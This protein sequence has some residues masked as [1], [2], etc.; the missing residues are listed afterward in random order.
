M[1]NTTKRV[2]PTNT[3]S[4]AERRAAFWAGVE[5]CKQAEGRPPSSPNPHMCEELRLCWNSG[6]NSVVE[7]F[8]W[9]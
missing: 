3:K 9:H 5:A 6:W 8:A 1:N 2:A 7:V 4:L